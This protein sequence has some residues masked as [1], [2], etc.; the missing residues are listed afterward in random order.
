[1]L[2]SGDK[3]RGTCDLGLGSSSIPCELSLTFNWRVVEGW[4]HYSRTS[5]AAV[6]PNGLL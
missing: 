6:G 3:G 5:N 1:M 2:S 4:A